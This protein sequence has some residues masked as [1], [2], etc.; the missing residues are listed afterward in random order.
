MFAPRALRV[1]AGARPRA[2]SSSTNPL[3]G[4]VI[5]RAHRVITPPPPPPGSPAW[6]RP[7][8]TTYAYVLGF[9]GTS[10]LM[11]WYFSGSST[12]EGGWVARSL[13]R[14]ACAGACRMV[15]A[16]CGPRAPGTVCAPLF[17]CV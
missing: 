11:Y 7:S 17:L 9:G 2:L 10:Y 16:F 15:V 12:K 8:L 14:R 4:V 6:N 13:P 5:G 1:C 3:P